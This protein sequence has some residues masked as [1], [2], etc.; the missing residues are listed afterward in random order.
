MGIAQETKAFINKQA[1]L[2]QLLNIIPVHPAT[3]SKRDLLELNLSFLD[4]DDKGK[5][6]AF[7]ARKKELE[8]LL[9]ILVQVPDY[10]VQV[11]KSKKTHYWSKHLGINDIVPPDYLHHIID[12]TLENPFDLYP[13]N[14]VELLSSDFEKPQSLLSIKL[15]KWLSKIKYVSNCYSLR[16]ATRNIEIDDTIY[17]ALF[18]DKKLQCLYHPRNKPE[19]YEYTL[20]PLGLISNGD[21][22]YLFA[23]VHHDNSQKNRFQ[24]F[25][26]NRFVNVSVLERSVE[27]S[28]FDFYEYIEKNPTTTQYPENDFYGTNNENK[29][30][31]VTLGV[32]KWMKEKYQ[33]NPIAD[34]QIIKKTRDKSYFKITINVPITMQFVWFL[35]AQSEN[36]EVLKPKKLRALIITRLKNTLKL[37][38]Q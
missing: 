20:S 5:T 26:L 3:I 22:R 15:E 38:E 25:A 30:V 29:P 18:D 11:D 33:Q 27:P 4:K 31:E 35:Q 19:P 6:R 1:T 24:S 10:K 17:N 9:S 36:I 16:H 14:L 37:Y 12:S 28:N 21:V 23:N 32:E 2:K 34:G 13:P 7:E 8:R